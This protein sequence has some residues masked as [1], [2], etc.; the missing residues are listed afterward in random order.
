MIGSRARVGL[1]P[2]ARMR[3]SSVTA[4]KELS[5]SAA[6]SDLFLDS[7]HDHAHLSLDHRILTWPRH[8]I[9][10]SAAR[11]EGSGV[12]GGAR[13]QVRSV[14]GC[15]LCGGAGYECRYL[16]SRNV[17]LFSTSTTVRSSK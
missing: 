14:A 10:R 7:M 13:R 17:R 8:N 6:G 2:C 4:V 16:I 9:R 3:T 1:G 15:T 5:N 12:R 11:Y